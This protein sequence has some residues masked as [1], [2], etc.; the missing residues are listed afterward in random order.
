[1]L[2]SV[3]VIPSTSQIWR[4]VSSKAGRLATSSSATTSQ[5]PLVE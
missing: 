1:M 2:V 4:R 3:A 5:R